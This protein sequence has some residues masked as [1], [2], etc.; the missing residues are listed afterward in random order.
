MFGSSLVVMLSD[1]LLGN[2]MSL[3]LC[4]SL[5]VYVALCPSVRVCVCVR[6]CLGVCKPHFKKSQCV[7]DVVWFVCSLVFILLRPTF[8]L[9]DYLC[10]SLPALARPPGFRSTHICS[11]TM[12]LPLSPRRCSVG[13]RVMFGKPQPVH[14]PHTQTSVSQ[15]R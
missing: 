1:F 11:S 5:S 2:F 15:M 14:G 7:G 13:V 12:T 3:Q 6:V 9:P 10:A 8:Q 4:F